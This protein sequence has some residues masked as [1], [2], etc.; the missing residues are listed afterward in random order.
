MVRAWT[1]STASNRQAYASRVNEEIRTF[2]RQD[3]EYEDWVEKYG[4][5][6]LTQSP[7]PPGYMLHDS[8]CL[9]LGRDGD[10]SL[11]LT[12]KPRRW[13]K[14]RHALIGWTERE[15]GERPA[16]CRTCM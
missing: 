10:L 14:S 16:L 11:H 15:V 4:G 1:V 9:H 3:R 13:A 8:E 12:E 6:V 2:H 7:T 5:Y